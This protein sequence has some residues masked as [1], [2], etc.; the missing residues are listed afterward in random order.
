MAAPRSA[1]P[2]AP[3]ATN[4][5]TRRAMQGNRRADTAPEIALRRR[6]HAAGL[7]FRKDHRV[8]VEGARARADIVFPR[9]RV[10]VFVDGCYWHG[11]PD[12]CRMPAR[13]ADYWQAKI[14]R[15][16]ERDE[17][18]TAALSA[19]GWRVVRVWEH[20]PVEA[21]VALVRAALSGR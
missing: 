7:R 15:N 4:A 13:N 2:P 8:E 18:V 5:A 11:C 16:R 12:H 14:G 17:R 20:E 6:L 3:P 19:S 1:L 10:A 21:A 9:R